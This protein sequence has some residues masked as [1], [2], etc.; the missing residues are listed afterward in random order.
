MILIPL[1]TGQFVLRVPHS[2]QTCEQR[3]LSD[4]SEHICQQ[5]FTESATLEHSPRIGSRCEKASELC[6]RNSRD[7]RHHRN[8]RNIPALV[9]EAA[10]V[11]SGPTGVN[12]K[13]FQR[14]FVTVSTNMGDSWN[15][16][17][18]GDSEHGSDVR[19]VDVNSTPRN[20]V[21]N[22]AE[23]GNSAISNRSDRR[24]VSR[25]SPTPVCTVSVTDRAC[26]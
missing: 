19:V 25:K 6:D 15:R 2:T 11:G 16:E 13:L 12:W 22:E 17:V 20:R 18:D 1:V 8:S 7:N 14:S 21:R 5:R 24:F 10:Q 9:G 23:Y 3:C 26:D 4:C